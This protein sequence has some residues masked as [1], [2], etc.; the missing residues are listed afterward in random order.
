M[1][2]HDAL[3]GQICLPVSCFINSVLMEWADLAVMVFVD[4]M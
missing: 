1:C 3:D 4:T 2:F